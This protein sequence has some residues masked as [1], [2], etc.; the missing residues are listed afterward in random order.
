MK[1]IT[2]ALVIL[3]LASPVVAAG[4]I[5]RACNKSDRNASRSLCKCIQRVANNELTRSDQKLA[6][7][8]FKEPHM[9]Q[10]TRQSDSST[11]ERFWKRYKKFGQTASENCG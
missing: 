8:F 2:T 9:A 7:K 3:C 10:E 6:A 1:K 5:E 4:K 11:K